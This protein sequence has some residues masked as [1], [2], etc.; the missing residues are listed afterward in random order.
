[1]KTNLLRLFAMLFTTAVMSQAGHIMQGV[2]AVNMSMGGAA[3]GQPLDISGALQWNPAAISTFDGKILKLDVGLFFSSPELYGK[4][5]ENML[6]QPGDFG[7]GTPGSPVISG[8]T[9]DDRGVSPLPNVAFVWDYD[10]SKHTFGVSAFGISGFGVTFPENTNSPA[11]AMGNPNPNFNPT[12]NNNP[13]NWPQAAMGFGHI[14]SDYMLLQVGLAWAYQLSDKFSIGVQPNFNYAALE[15]AP[16]PTASPNNF[17]YANTDKASALGFGAQFGIFYDS[18]FGLKLGASYK[19]NQTFSEFEFENTYPDGSTATNKFQM[20]YP[21]IFSLGAGYTKGNFDLA[22]D[23]RRI[24]YEN[25][26]GFNNSG[27]TQTG[28]VAGFGWDNI[29]V[30]SAGIQYKGVNKLPIRLGYT[31]SSGPIPDELTFFNIPATAIIKNAYQ[32]GL[33]YIINDNW[34]V[35]G[36]FHYGDSSGSKSGQILNPMM[37]SPTNPLGAIPGSEVSYDMTTSMVM[38]GLSYTFN[39]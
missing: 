33:S 31:Y 23:F 6:W 20:D 30:V 39:K 35:D 17:G 22:L 9:E 37:V 28:S 4:L 29:S 5:P 27:W 16:N 3:T 18:G 14:E 7:P 24:D 11:D 12:G 2:G 36:V 32:F 26:E 1:M 25:T 38:F 8:T 19:T 10:D 13:I 34:Q 15:L 21:A